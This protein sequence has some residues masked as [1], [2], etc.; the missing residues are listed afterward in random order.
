MTHHLPSTIKPLLGKQ[1][2]RF[3][4]GDPAKLIFTDGTELTVNITGD[5]YSNSYIY[6]VAQEGDPHG[7]ELLDILE[8]DTDSPQ[9]D[10]I[11]SFKST[12]PPGETYEGDWLSQWDIRFRFAGGCVLV[13]HINDSNG[14]YDG[15]TDYTIKKP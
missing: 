4:K 9:P 3:E 1:L 15:Y 13:R 7:T 12:Q 2:L 11:E 10:A 14:Y 8:N 5:C 6:D